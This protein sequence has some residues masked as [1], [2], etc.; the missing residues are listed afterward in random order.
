[1][2]Q[3]LETVRSGHR[4]QGWYQQTHLEGSFTHPPGSF[5]RLLWETV[6]RSKRS[7][8]SV[9]HLVVKTGF[10]TEHEVHGL[11]RLSG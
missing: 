5:C 2:P 10:P 11:A 1:M 9:F 8:S 6:H 3:T 7:A 4:T